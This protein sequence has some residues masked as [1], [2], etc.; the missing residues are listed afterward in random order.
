MYSFWSDVFKVVLF[1]LLL[2]FGLGALVACDPEAL[3]RMGK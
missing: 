3:L 2:V 1:L